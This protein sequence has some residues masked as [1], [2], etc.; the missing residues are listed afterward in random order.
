MKRICLLTT[1]FPR[2]P[3]DEASVFL[4][5]LVEGY[6]DSGAS[7]IVI[8]PRDKTEEPRS[9]CGNFAIE[10]FG[11]GVFRRG[12]LAFGAGIMPNIRRNPTLLL[13]A[14]MLLL[15]LT[16]LAIVKRAEYDVLHANWALA[17]LAAWV[18]SY[19]TKK[20]YVVT[21]RGEDIPLIR[22]PILRLLCG[23]ALKRAAAIVSV[24]QQFLTDIRSVVKLDS[25]KCFVVPNGVSVRVPAPAESAAFLATRGLSGKKFAL[26]VGT[27]IPRKR[28]E[29]LVRALKL[30]SLQEHYLV[31]CGRLDDTTYV[32][33]LK[34]LAL[35]LGVT[36]RLRL[37]GGTAP[38]KIPLYLQ[39]AD[40]YLSASTF[41][42]RPNAVLEA[43]SAGTLVAVSEI[44]AHAEIVQHGVNGFLFNADEISTLDRILSGEA[45][46]T[47]VRTRVREAASKSLKGHSWES[48]A[49]SYL[50]IFNML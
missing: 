46:S 35:E 41:E 28:V 18:A 10:R 9:T 37:E 15:Q 1:S 40:L 19:V 17:L 26:F 30:P 8:V 38:S 25:E 34:K 13:Q 2:F 14:P 20:P 44:A 4:Q 50:N 12:A 27:V 22:K 39:A 29:A 16:R 24:N 23:L 42:G 48:C 11:Y 6:S 32:E 7:G 36:E 45:A 3:D 21:L 33:E 47:V 31:I 43:L 49:Q 5:R